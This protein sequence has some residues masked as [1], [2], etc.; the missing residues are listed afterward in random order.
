M[1]TMQ[2]KIN[3]LCSTR[4][5]KKLFFEQENEFFKVETAVLKRLISRGVWP[6]LQS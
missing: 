6:E 1:G 2:F 4:M 3:V 5:L